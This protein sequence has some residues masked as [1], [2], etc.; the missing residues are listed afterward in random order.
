MKKFILTNTPFSVPI[1]VTKLAS[2]IQS[3]HFKQYDEGEVLK[4]VRQIDLNEDEVIDAE[5]LRRYREL[6]SDKIHR[7]M[8]NVEVEDLLIK[9]R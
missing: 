1:N 9:L 3:K 7:Q 2:L 4:Y 5:D 8:S 6:I